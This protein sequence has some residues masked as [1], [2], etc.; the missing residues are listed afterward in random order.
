MTNLIK[1]FFTL[2]LIVYSTPSFA[3]DAVTEPVDQPVESESYVPPAEASEG[4]GGW[5]IVDPVTQIVHGVDVCTMEVCGPNGI[6][7]G[8]VPET[9]TEC[10]KCVYRFQTKSTSDNNVAGWHGGNVKYK[11]ETQTF[12]MTNKYSSDEGDVDEVMIITPSKTA[13]DGKDLYTGVETKTKFKTRPINNQTAVVET[14]KEDS[15]D[16]IVPVKVQYEQWNGGT[17]F[18][19]ESV[20]QFESN[21]N[22]D[23]ESVLTSCDTC[24]VD[25]EQDEEYRNAFYETVTALTA[26]VKSFISSLFGGIVI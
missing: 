26:K 10:P 16:I 4:I 6:W 20:E 22:T 9:Y 7:N 17:S 2:F 21:I 12:E 24:N 3:E 8:K 11:S 25:L 19:Y 18:F 1:I 23:V 13:S 14:V 5:A 15:K